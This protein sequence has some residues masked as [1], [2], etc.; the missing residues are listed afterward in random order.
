M[1]QSPRSKPRTVLPP[2]QVFVLLVLYLAGSINATLP[3]PFI[4]QVRAPVW[5]AILFCLYTGQLVSGLGIAQD[6]V[7]YYTGILDSLSYAGE[8]ISVLQWG[9]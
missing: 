3:S 9:R 2:L 6:K 8:A 7:G 4:V 5:L 1:E